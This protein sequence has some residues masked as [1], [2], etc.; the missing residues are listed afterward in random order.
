MIW[1]DRFAIGIFILGFIGFAV[2]LGPDFNW[3]M[4]IVP[5]G[6]L[7]IISWIVLRTFDFMFGGPKRRK[8]QR[9]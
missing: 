9:H 2:I 4:T 5:A 3:Q 6:I 1:A 8:S 7:A